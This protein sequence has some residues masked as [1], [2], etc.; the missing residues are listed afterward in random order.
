[1]MK[2]YFLSAMSGKQETKQFYIAPVNMLYLGSFFIRV[3]CSKAYNV[4]RR[5]Q[6]VGFIRL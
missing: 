1:M 3:H 6:G 5:N 2:K 4:V